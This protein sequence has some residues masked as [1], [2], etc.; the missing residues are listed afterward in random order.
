MSRFNSVVLDVD[1]TL[2][3]VEG[4]D[5]L[6]SLRG[7]EVEAWS[8]TLTAEAMAGKLSLDTVY[9]KRLDVVRPDREEVS[10]LGKVYVSRIAPSASETLRELSKRRIDV[11]MVSGGLREAILPL[12]GL[13]GI[14]DDRLCAVSIFF[15]EEG[16]YKGF[17]E[18]SPLASQRGKPKAVQEMKLAH[19]ILAVGDGMTD[20]EMKPAVDGFAAYTGFV[21]REQV[22][23]GAD[24]VIDTFRALKDL[25]LG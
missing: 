14:K 9:R 5:W 11:A 7:K 12:A 10:E 21:R 4:I 22:V 2:S 18:S 25:V 6:A 8:A 15:D 13:L 16:K 20:L 23:E 3:G 1:S 19:P 24:F 17:D